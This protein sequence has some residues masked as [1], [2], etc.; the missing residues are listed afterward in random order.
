MLRQSRQRQDVLLKIV[1]AVKS[2]TAKFMCVRYYRLNETEDEEKPHRLVSYFPKENRAVLLV[3]MIKRI[4]G[5][6]KRIIRL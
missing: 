3:A 5:A 2:G 4:R 6:S 1:C